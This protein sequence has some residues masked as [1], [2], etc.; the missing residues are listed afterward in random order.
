MLKGSKHRMLKDTTDRKDCVEVIE[1]GRKDANNKAHEEKVDQQVGE[2]EDEAFNL[3][4]TYRKGKVVQLHDSGANSGAVVLT[5]LSNV[6]LPH[7]CNYYA[8]MG[9]NEMHLVRNQFLYGVSF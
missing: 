8:S 7:D 9:R 1:G 2:E 5:F 3:K 4:F 6:T